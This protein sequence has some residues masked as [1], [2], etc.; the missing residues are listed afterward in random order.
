MTAITLSAENRNA[1]PQ[2]PKR[3]AT[4]LASATEIVAALGCRDWI[5]GRSHEC[6]HPA[7]IGAVPVLTEPKFPI[8]GTSQ[9]IDREV[10]A[11]IEDGVSVYHVFAEKLKELRPQVIV[12]QDQCEVCAV[13]LKDVEQALSQWTGDDVQ[14][15]SCRPSG[16]G[17]I[18]S[19]IR[20]IADALGVPDNGD[21]LVFTM[22]ARMNAIA[23]RAST[24]SS[25]TRVLCI[26]WIDPL[27]SSSGWMPEVV[28]LSGGT[29]LLSEPGK[30]SQW[31]TWENVLAADPDA[32]V[33]MPCGFDIARAGGE[34]PFL[35]DKP[36][37][38][39][40]RAVRDGRVA[41]V[42]GS[43]YFNRP[44]PRLVES[45]EILAEILHPELFDFGHYGDGWVEW[46]GAASF[47]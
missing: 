35:E 3:V 12:T 14:V 46:P 38:A 8:D 1:S 5:I 36:G 10:K 6:D 17:D 15:V 43:Q 23:A 11:L 29:S 34:L 13:S 39:G 32:I 47:V 41:V 2:R 22:Q 42:D 37:F 20:R 19:D 4:L 9:A 44:G 25:R 30:H 28:Q 24:A 16:L 7:G 33:V 27:M 40:L 21:R 26:E 18:W 31:I 45:L